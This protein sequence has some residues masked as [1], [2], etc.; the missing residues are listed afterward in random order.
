MMHHW[1]RIIDEERVLEWGNLED[2]PKIEIHALQLQVQH[3]SIVP[4]H[5]L[6]I[7][8]FKSHL[9]L[10]RARGLQG[11]YRKGGR[12]SFTKGSPEKIINNLEGVLLSCRVAVIIHNY[13][14]FH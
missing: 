6:W 11:N 7:G 5:D 13:E 14:I 10:R 2:P 1:E 8:N 9:V 12:S 4:P 3:S